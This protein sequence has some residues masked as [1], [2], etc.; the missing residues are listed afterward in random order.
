MVVASHSTGRHLRSHII[1]S[2]GPGEQI[3]MSVCNYFC[4]LNLKK[5]MKATLWLGGL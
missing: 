3:L 4:N 5:Q 2:L 1:Q